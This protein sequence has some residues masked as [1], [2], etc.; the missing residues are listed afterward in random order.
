MKVS[1]T[2]RDFA[3]TAKGI[4]LE[5][6]ANSLELSVYG[7]P[8]AASIT[9]RGG[10]LELWEVLEWLRCPVMVSSDDGERLWWGFVSEVRVRENALEVGATIDSMCNAVAVAY[11]YVEPG[12][13]VVGTRKTTSWVTDAESIAEFGRKDFLSSQDGM[14]DATAEARRD[15]ILAA[16]RWPQA[17]PMQTSG[18]M[19]RGRVRYS[20]AKKSMSATIYCRGWWSTLGWRMASVS[21]TTDTATTTQISNLVSTYGALITSTSIEAASGISSSEYRDGD[22]DALTEILGL[23]GSGGANGRRLLATVDEYRRLYIYEEPAITTVE[24]GLNSH[25]VVLYRGQQIREAKAPV[26]EWIRML[27]VIPGNVDQSKLISPETQ[28]VEG[29]SWSDSSG[30]RLKFRGQPSIE[31]MGKVQR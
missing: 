4:N 25:G 1:V 6:K 19:P 15:A 27:G 31:E 5:L 8:A 12:S 30:M 21:G 18:M 2:S 26:G 10:A 11:S 9:V 24:Y 20:G 17:P 7:G 22:S 29:A 16:R 28:F 13:Q 14:S 23:M 3:G